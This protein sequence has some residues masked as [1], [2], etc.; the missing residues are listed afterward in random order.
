M[1]ENDHSSI[2][3][4]EITAAAPGPVHN[5]GSQP[6]ICNQD[7]DGTGMGASQAQMFGVR[8][9]GKSVAKKKAERRRGKSALSETLLNATSG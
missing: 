9:C 7:C 2:Q 1:T 3:E 6:D 4:T 5:H 8:A